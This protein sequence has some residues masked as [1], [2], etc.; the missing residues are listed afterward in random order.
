MVEAAVVD[1]DDAVD[2]GGERAEELLGHIVVELAAG[3]LAVLVHVEYLEKAHGFELR[4]PCQVLPAKLY[5][6]LI[7]CHVSEQGRDQPIDG[8]ELLACATLSFFDCLEVLMGLL[9][10]VATEIVVESL[11]KLVSEQILLTC[12]HQAIFGEQS[13]SDVSKLSLD[14]EQA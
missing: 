4:V 8:G 9:L 14:V 6:G 1:L 10:V 7:G 13:I 11:T 5:E 12:V 3:N 2:V